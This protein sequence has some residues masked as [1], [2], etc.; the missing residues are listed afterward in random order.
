MAAEKDRPCEDHNARVFGDRKALNQVVC[1]Q[2]PKE[3]SKVEDCSD[4]G[5]ALAFKAKVGDQGIGRGI[6]EGEF[7]KEL[8]CVCY[9]DLEWS[10]LL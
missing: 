4:P 2:G 10:G 3:I 6:V 1:W 7:V 8:D 5:V 9:A